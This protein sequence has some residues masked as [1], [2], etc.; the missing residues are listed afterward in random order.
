MA[1]AG[2]MAGLFGLLHY[3][4]GP[5]PGRLATVDTTAQPP[6]SVDTT[7]TPPT[8]TRRAAPTTRAP[9]TTAGPRVVDGADVTN[10]FGDVQV[11][12]VVQGG[13]I[14]D[15]QALTLPQDRQRSAYISQVAGPRLRIEVLQAQSASI[16]IVSGATYT[17]QSYA[18]SVQSALDRL[19]R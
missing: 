8:T 15:V 7:T 14:T 17:S 11:R 12:L 3:K 6:A 18:Q 19:P 1:I 9:S 2:T 4:S 10:R 5:P 16:H 13:R